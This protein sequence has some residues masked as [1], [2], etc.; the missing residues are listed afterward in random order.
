MSC[1]RSALGLD[2][3]PDLRLRVVVS[4]P[5]TTVVGYPTT[6]GRKCCHAVDL[7]SG[8]GHDADLRPSRCA[9]PSVTVPTGCTRDRR[10]VLTNHDRPVVRHHRVRRSHH[11]VAFG[12]GRDSGTAP[13]LVAL[14]RAHRHVD[15]RRRPVVPQ[16]REALQRVRAGSHEPT[17]GNARRR[18][19]KIQSGV[20]E[21]RSWE[22]LDGTS[23][24]GRCTARADPQD[25]P[26]DEPGEGT[27]GPRY[28]SRSKP[29]PFGK[30]F[31]SYTL[32]QRSGRRRVA[33]Q[34]ARIRR[35]APPHDTSTDKRPDRR[36]GSTDPPTDPPATELAGHR[37]S[38]AHQ[39]PAHP[40]GPHW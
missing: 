34:K 36:G 38:A 31:P 27:T 24:A 5:L 11:Q 10:R 39:R 32:K 12:F 28:S 21:K 26:Q 2:G 37:C 20:D 14:D 29:C 8:S 9:L 17:L 30:C 25:E 15:H 23:Q 16:R 1:P 35:P 3:I 6:E 22:Q 33:R 13:L 18:P 4:L 7:A 40:A 19:P